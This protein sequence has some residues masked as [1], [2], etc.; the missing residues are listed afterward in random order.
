MFANAYLWLQRPEQATA[1]TWS[2]APSAKEEIL[3]KTIPAPRPRLTARIT[4]S[5]ALSSAVTALA[6]AG[7][8]GSASAAVKIGILNDQSGVYADFGGKWSVEA[9]KMAV[10]DFGG[11]V[12]GMPIEIVYG[13]PPEQARHRLQHR[14]PVV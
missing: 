10:E 5:L 3:T 14:A 12:L 2:G 13:R 8:V 6:L 9:A 4:R 1:R 7:A 11:K